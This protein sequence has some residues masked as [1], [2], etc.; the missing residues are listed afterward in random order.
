MVLL[1]EVILKRRERSRD[2]AKTTIGRPGKCVALIRDLEMVAPFQD[3]RFRGDDVN[4][5]V[6]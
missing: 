3:P 2:K 5:V 4:C 6:F 1:T